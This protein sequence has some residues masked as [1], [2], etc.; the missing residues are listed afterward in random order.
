MK[1]LDGEMSTDLSVITKMTQASTVIKVVSGCIDGWM[2]LPRIY[3][4][5]S[6]YFTIHTTKISSSY[7]VGVLA[8]ECYNG[9]RRGLSEVLLDNTVCGWV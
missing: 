5:A 6:L 8:E 2:E 1:G 4:H 9:N 3:N 7:N